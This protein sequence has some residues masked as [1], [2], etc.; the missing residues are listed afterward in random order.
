MLIQLNTMKDRLSLPAADTQ[1]DE[2]L[3]RAIKAVSAR[4]DRCCNRALARTAGFV[5][6][7]PADSLE[8]AA[9]CYPV[10][11][12]SRFEVRR[13][14]ATDWEERA[15]VQYQLRHGC[16]FRLDAPL[17]SLGEEGRVIYTGGYVL[18]GATPAAGQ[19]A[20]RMTCTRRPWNRW[21]SG[22][23]TGIAPA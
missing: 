10:E 5:Q 6:E 8:I 11:T 9:A 4:F 12:V 16:L 15:G 23:R 21:R 20:C 14:G 22:S 2:L 18:P 19:T 3:L 13:L 1:Y 7:F 17:G